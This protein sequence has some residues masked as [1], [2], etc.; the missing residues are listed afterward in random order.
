MEHQDW[1][2]ISF[3][4]TSKLQKKEDAKK[5]HSNKTPD[6]ETTRLEVPKEMGK[7]LA[8]ARATKGKT[9][10]QLAAE[11]GIAQSILGRW[12]SDKEIPTNAQIAA[13]E[14]NLGIKLPRGKKVAAK[15][16]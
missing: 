10:K 1:N 12:E 9:Q 14:K 4:N 13:I 8:Q 5:V 7:L 2:H 3:N 6:P 16:I 11:L 15:E